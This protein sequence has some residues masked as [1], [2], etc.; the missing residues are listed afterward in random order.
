VALPEAQAEFVRRL[1][2]S[3]KPVAVAAFGGPYLIRQFPEANV[4]LTAYAIEDV[5]QSAAVR[6][7]FGEVPARGR[8]PVRIPG[9]FEMGAGIQLNVRE[10]KGIA[11]EKVRS[12]ND[13]R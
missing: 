7:L 1:I 5:A 3:G 4:Y 12:Q 6:V 2:A 8:L 13:E 9:L 10:N 11:T